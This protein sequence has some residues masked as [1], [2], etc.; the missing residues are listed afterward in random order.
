[1]AASTTPATTDSHP[2]GCDVDFL[3][4]WS[5]DQ[6]HGVLTGT[7]LA[8]RSGLLGDRYL[9]RWWVR[10]CDTGATWTRTRWVRARRIIR[11]R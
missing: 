11:R 9:L 6:G 3:K 10:S 2:V 7:V 8:H 1:M 5:V 4:G